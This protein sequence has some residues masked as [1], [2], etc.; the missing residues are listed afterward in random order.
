MASI[1]TLETEILINILRYVSLMKFFS[2][3]DGV[4]EHSLRVFA[5]FPNIDNIYTFHLQAI[6]TDE[7]SLTSTSNSTSLTKVSG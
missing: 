1:S 3:I 4:S 7:A 6:E 2:Q 5:L